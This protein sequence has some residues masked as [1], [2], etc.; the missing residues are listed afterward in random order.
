MSCFDKY[1]LFYHSVELLTHCETQYDFCITNNNKEQQKHNKHGHDYK[2]VKR[3]VTGH[4]CAIKLVSIMVKW[5][6]VK[7]D[8]QAGFP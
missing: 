3:F 4:L 6:P 5:L 8:S 2:I 7:R 1:T